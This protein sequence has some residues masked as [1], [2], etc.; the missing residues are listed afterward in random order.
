[1]KW[2][3]TSSAYVLPRTSG[4]VDAWSEEAGARGSQRLAFV[5][6]VEP[7]EVV[8]E[9]LGLDAEARATVR[10]R[11][12]FVD[13]EPVELTDSY[14]PE[15]VAAGTALAEATK[16]KG[17]APT[18]L[19]ELGFTPDAVTEDLELRPATPEE[20]EVLHMESGVSVLTLMR[21]C[22]AADGEP[23]EVS[24]MVMRGPRR[25]R[26]EMKAD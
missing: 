2:T 1:M 5:G 18:L 12:M 3:S 21:T 22:R 13:N 15:P 6:E 17:G 9:A 26:Y 11:V 25:L 10:R 23:Y 19:A 4:Q 24:L 16:I 14:Y 7:P 20:A 8:R